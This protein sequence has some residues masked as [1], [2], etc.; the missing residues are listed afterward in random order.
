VPTVDVRRCFVTMHS[1]RVTCAST[2][3]SIPTI[4]VQPFP[5]TGIKYQ[6]F[7]KGS[8]SPHHPRSSTDGK[9]LFDET[10]PKLTEFE[11]VSVTT[12]P[13]FPRGQMEYVRSQNDQITVPGIVPASFQN[14]TARA[15]SSQ[16]ARSRK[17]LKCVDLRGKTKMAELLIGV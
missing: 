3:P 1:A 10:N 11:V 4:Y 15:N 2:E 12:Q 13:R 5:A 16:I 6:L 14:A 8:D 9:E 7:A 17:L